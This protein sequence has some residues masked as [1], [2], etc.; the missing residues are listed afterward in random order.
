MEMIEQNQ[1]STYECPECGY[2]KKDYKGQHIECPKCGKQKGT[3][4]KVEEIHKEAK[5]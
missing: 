5:P 2:I 3:Y 1:L 4:D